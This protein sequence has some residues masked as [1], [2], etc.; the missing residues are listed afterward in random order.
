MEKPRM[1]TVEKRR[2]RVIVDR[3]KT[4]YYGY[5]TEDDVIV[6]D[7]VCLDDDLPLVELESLPN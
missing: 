3:A 1:K 4:A 2:V 7:V 6:S 5:K